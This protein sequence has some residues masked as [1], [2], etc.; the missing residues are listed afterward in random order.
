MPRLGALLF[1]SYKMRVRTH[2]F[3]TFYAY[4]VAFDRIE[5][6]DSGPILHFEA[7]NTYRVSL[8]SQGI[9]FF[10]GFGG[11]GTRT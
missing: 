6:R 8:Y 7:S 5:V 3:R 10:F 1:S 2:I 9:Y 11:F 4:I